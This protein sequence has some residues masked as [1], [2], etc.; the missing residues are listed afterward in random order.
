MHGWST[1]SSP[2]F[3]I[4][5]ATTP[6]KMGIATVTDGAGTST[7]VRVQWVKPS[8][9]GATITEYKVLFKDKAG[10]GSHTVTECVGTSN[11]ALQS[12]YCDV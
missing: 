10:T 4:L 9:R 1:W 8:E 12:Y 3:G 5:A 7:S 2:A 11:I 6:A